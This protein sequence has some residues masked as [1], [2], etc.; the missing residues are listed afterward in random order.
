MA[1]KPSAA[2]KNR[3]KEEGTLNMNSMMDMLTIMLLFLLVNFSTSGALGTKSE[4]FQPA[5]VLAKNKPKKSL[6]I[7]ISSGHIFFNKDALVEVDKIAAQQKSYII[8]ELAA[9]LDEEAA[10]ATDLETRFGIEFKHELII[11]GDYRMPFNILLKV[12]YTCGKNAY[13]NLR[14]LGQLSN[15]NEI[16]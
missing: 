1:F 11:N 14:L 13:S 9:K 10:K 2:K 4:G 16:M 6:V 15:P 7:T 8:E 3:A 5:K 12:V